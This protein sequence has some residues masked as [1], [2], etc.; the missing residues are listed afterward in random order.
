L[1]AYQQTKAQLFSLI[2]VCRLIHSWNFRTTSCTCSVVNELLYWIIEIQQ[3]FA[4][5]QSCWKDIVHL[6]KKRFNKDIIN[7][8]FVYDTI[9]YIRYTQKQKRLETQNNLNVFGSR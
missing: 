1:E 7:I 4:I 5:I 9:T 6:E 2:N 3:V 8:S